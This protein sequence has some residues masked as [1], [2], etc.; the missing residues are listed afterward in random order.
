MK[1]DK[2]ERGNK[3][4]LGRSSSGNVLFRQKI[5]LATSQNQFGRRA[6]SVASEKWKNTGNRQNQ[7]EVSSP[8][9]SHNSTSLIQLLPFKKKKGTEKWRERGKEGGKEKGSP[10]RGDGPETAHTST[11]CLFPS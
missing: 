2:T 1:K 4:H 6:C 11:V 9:D 5:V 8:T 10:A 7:H 3:I